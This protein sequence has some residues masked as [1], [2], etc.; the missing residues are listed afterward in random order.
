M[1]V[2]KRRFIISNGLTQFQKL[3]NPNYLLSTNWSPR[4]ATG[5]PLAK[6]QR[7]ENQVCDGVVSVLKLVG[8]RNTGE[9]SVSVQVLRQGK[10]DIPIQGSQARGVSS[11][12]IQDFS[13]LGKTR[14]TTLGRTICF[15][16]SPNSK[17]NL[18]QK[19]LTDTLNIR[20]GPVLDTLWPSHV[21]PQK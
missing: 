2:Y 13:W 10:I 18:S 9:L 15:P 1:C 19:H 11:W 4:Q 6:I 21:D 8:S 3:R 14:S 20:P 5:I 12:S 16:Q 17:V 7:S